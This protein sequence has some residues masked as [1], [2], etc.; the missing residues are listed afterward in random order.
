MTEWHVKN[1]GHLIPNFFLTH[2]TE[3]VLFCSGAGKFCL[4]LELRQLTRDV[5]ND[6]RI[7]NLR[8]DVT[9]GLPRKTPNDVRRR[10]LC[11][12]KCHK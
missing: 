1:L 3:L 4:A 5:K 2:E 12:V 10:S 7:L 9:Y 8:S 11:E 6:V